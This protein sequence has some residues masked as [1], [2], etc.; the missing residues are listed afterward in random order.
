M[1]ART[2]ENRLFR[3]RLWSAAA[4]I[5]FAMQA[6]TWPT[7]LPSSATPLTPPSIYARWWTMTEACSGHTRDFNA[8]RWYHTPGSTVQLNGA[9]VSGFYSH[10]GHY[11]VVTD[12]MVDNGAGVRHE[13]LHA[14]LDVVGHPRDQFLGACEDVVN[15]GGPCALDAGAWA[16]PAPYVSLSVDSMNVSSDVQLLPRE[17]DGQRWVVLTVTAMNPLSR[18]IIAVPNGAHLSWGFNNGINSM[19][20][21]VEDSS[22]LYFAANQTRSWLFEFRVAESEELYTLPIGDRFI[23]GGFG[24]NFTPFSKVTIVP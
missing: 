5:A 2:L 8:I 9:D 1:R 3:R 22:N 6:C 10:S 7:D 23:D 15:C 12:A 19:S 17:T 24:Q 4:A 11:V 13:M 20:L 14:L 21:P 16:P 18:A